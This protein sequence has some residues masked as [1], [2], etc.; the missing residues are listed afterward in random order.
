MDSEQFDYSRSSDTA[1]LSYFGRDMAENFRE[2][3]KYLWPRRLVKKLRAIK[4]AAGVFFEQSPY[5]FRICFR[6]HL[7]EQNFEIGL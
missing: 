3:T 5:T 6:D 4:E 7:E 2:N 1:G